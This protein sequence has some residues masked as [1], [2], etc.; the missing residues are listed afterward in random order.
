MQQPAAHTTQ[1]QKS[2]SPVAAAAAISSM[3]PAAPS[4]PSFPLGQSPPKDIL[5]AVVNLHWWNFAL[6]HQWNA[7]CSYQGQPM[8]CQYVNAHSS[9]TNL[10]EEQRQKIISRADG[11]VFHI[12]GGDRPAGARPAAPSVVFSAESPGNNKCMRTV[13]TMQKGHIDMSYQRCAVV[14]AGCM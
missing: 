4:P 12:C 3:T 13:A 9:N 14:R 6:G 7:S 8:T 1:Q 11:L 5:V 2:S 10:T